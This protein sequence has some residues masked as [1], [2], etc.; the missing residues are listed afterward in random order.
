MLRYVF[1]V[2]RQAEQGLDR[3]CGGL[4]LGLALVKGLTELHGGAVQAASQGVN[5]GAQ[6]TIRLPLERKL[7]P[8]MP[9]LPANAVACNGKRSILVI[10]DNQDTAE[11]IC[12]LLRLD[13]HDVK[14]A[15][16]AISGLETARDFHPEIILCDIGLPGMDGYQIAHAI[17]QDDALSSAYVIAMTGYGR[18]KDR[19]QALDSGFNLHLTKPIDYD[20]LRRTLANMPRRI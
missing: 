7:S 6:F 12:L 3:S 18:E 13:G 14:T 15:M 8:A 9:E 4:G 17:R 10:E 1:D 5:K 19:R 2:F 11:S 16:T 20:N